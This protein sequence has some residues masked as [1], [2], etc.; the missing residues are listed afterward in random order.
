MN[1]FPLIK[2]TI[3]FICGI[4]LQNYFHFGGTFLIV[5]FPLLS[6]LAFISFYI[7]DITYDK[8]LNTFFI[9]LSI[10]LAGQF[11][12]WIS[13]R[14]AGNIPQKYFYENATVW[15]KI[16]SI[17][18][19]KENGFSFAITADSLTIRTTHIKT[20][21]NILCRFYGVN[22]SE[23]DSLYNLIAIGNKL[24][25]N[26]K[27]IKAKGIRNPG[28]F[29]YGSYL[30]REGIGGTLN[31][32]G[33]PGII[34][35]SN[36]RSFNDYL[37]RVRKSLDEK[38]S[39][40]H[41][42]EAA[43]LL[44][45]LLL[46]D[47]SLIDSNTKEYYINAGVVHVLAV[48]GL[49]VGFIV[50]IFLILFGRLNL[51]FRSFITIIG[52]FFFMLLT[53]MPPSVVRASVMSMILVIALLTSRSTNLYNSLSFA[54]LIILIFSPKELFNPGFQ[55]SF[56]A[57]LSIAVIYPYIEKFVKALRVNNILKN[58]MLIMG[59]SL[60]AQIGTIPFTLYYFG[61]LSL[62]SL[63][64]NL[65]VIPLIGVIVGIGIFTLSVG[66]LSTFVAGYF[67]A[68]NDLLVFFLNKFV[69]VSG[70]YEYSYLP[71]KNF[72]IQD[73]LIFYL[74]LISLAF[75]YKK[76]IHRSAIII[77]MLLALVNIIVFSSLD[78]KI[79]FTKNKFYLMMID[80]G[81][82]DS[83]LLKFPNGQTALIDA[84]IATPYFDN[85]ERVV[86]PLLNYLNIDKID[87]GF[88]SH[89]DVDHYAGFVSLIQANKIKKVIK[90]ALDSL[91]DK[92]VRFEKFIKAKKIPLDYYDKKIIKVG[93]CRIYVMNNDNHQYKSTTNDK[94]GV[95][96]IEYGKTTFLFTGDLGKETEHYYIEEYGRFL[97]ASV[98][99]ISHHGS[100]TGTSDE[101]LTLVKPGICLIS[102]GIGN[103]FGHPAQGIIDKI[104]GI[105]SEIL[106]T[107][108]QGA[109]LL[110][111]NG[112]KINI[113]RWKD[114]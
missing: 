76:F 39:E 92:D 57:V 90:P 63:F 34:I 103:R 95:L 87:Y 84:G 97:L 13:S 36:E 27:L 8:I 24:K 106:R 14:D 54:A 58:L 46:A 20:D 93:N 33:V 1:K 62:I 48:S 52:L 67:A 10:I 89:I 109:A 99:K 9:Y 69:S 102:A 43:A 45:G 83:F 4:I 21:M 59:L 17:N 31:N 47:R 104:S 2:F 85:G 26:G 81:Q 113:I 12:L 86:T 91:N 16:N 51:Y 50:L 98:L 55:L 101:F 42:P 41:L 56:A 110:Q 30:D 74:F 77:L 108:L 49:H 96:K 38:I 29:D 44:R 6:M 53:G 75:F 18:L 111:S 68:A 88:V 70:K 23:T 28:E 35:L 25:I 79:F 100:N 66:Y 73:I 71:I 37:F 60:S 32:S 22:N 114:L 64:A 7:K 82:G 19:K 80:V 40:L 65:V 61:K 3:L 15:G 78:D 105:K 72:S 107:D 5:S 112:E 11:T 94:S